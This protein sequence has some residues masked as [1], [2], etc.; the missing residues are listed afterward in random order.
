MFRSNGLARMQ[1]NANRGAEGANFEALDVHPNVNR[2]IDPI[3]LAGEADA[4]PY[5]KIEH[6]NLGFAT[7]SYSMF[8]NSLPVFSAWG[9]APVAT[10]FSIFKTAKD[11]I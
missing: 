9:A 3:V 6:V 8:L 11:T 4:T 7:A 5:L 1:V 10:S 2:V